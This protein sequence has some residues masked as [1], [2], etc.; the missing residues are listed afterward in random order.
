MLDKYFRI[1]FVSP[2]NLVCHHSM[3]GDS[4][5]EGRSE[6]ILPC[7]GNCLKRHSQLLRS[8]VGRVTP[9]G[10][11]CGVFLLSL[12]LSPLSSVNLQGQTSQRKT[13]ADPE[14]QVQ[15]YFQAARQAE[16]SGDYESAASN[17]RA[18]IKLLPDVAEVYHNLGLVYYLQK[19]DLDAIET[20][21]AALKLKPDL[22]GSSLFLGMAYLR[23]SQYEKAIDPLKRAIAQNPNESR[24]YLNLGLCYMETGRHE[25]AMKALQ[26]GLEHFPQDVEILYN[27][28]KVYTKMMTATFQRMAETEPDSYRV[29]QL[30]GESYEAR[31]ETTKAIE[32]YK[33]AI[34]RKP[35]APGLHYALGNVLWKEGNLE[36]AAKEFTRELEI[37]PEQYLATWKL[38]NIYLI[39][40][41]TDRAMAYLQ[42][43]LE[44][45]PDLGQA[46]R[47]LARAFSDKGD[48]TGAMEHL[49]KV[50]ELAPDEPAVHYRLAL[51]YKRLG[52][53]QE[54][55]A[56]MEKFQKL[57]AASDQ[58]QKAARSVQASG[59]EESERSKADIES[60]GQ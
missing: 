2:P 4:L 39:K 15:E 35:E 45:K 40:R 59:D 49:N 54:E 41:E 3:G 21:H 32:E 52:R 56:E 57:K 50:I 43:A 13:Q 5:Y 11:F 19:K 17:Y 34:A 22:P 30:L 27:L 53:T 60:E 38:G 12:L 28:G 51:L 29:H 25:E 20:F 23:S 10:G 31:R 42:R 58:R 36:E 9:R 33:A 46:H 37:N 26:N 7:Q 48:L 24:A 44:Q 18:V 8:F 1:R 16:K 6:K 55:R 47:D 14:A